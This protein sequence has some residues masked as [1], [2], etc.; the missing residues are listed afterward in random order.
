MEP[1]ILQR[2]SFTML[3]VEIPSFQRSLEGGEVLLSSS[4]ALSLSFVNLL[5]GKS[6]RRS[7]RGLVRAAGA[8]KKQAK[9]R[10]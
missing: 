3:R 6:S 4:G 1:P 9:R 8:A 10:C 5:Y 7:G 2:K